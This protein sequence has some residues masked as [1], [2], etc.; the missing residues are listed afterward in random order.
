M[1]KLGIKG[2]AKLDCFKDGKLLWTT[3]W[4]KNKITNASLAVYSGL[5]GNVGSQ[6]AFTY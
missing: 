3:G 2:F 5:T 4:L 6:V 1:N